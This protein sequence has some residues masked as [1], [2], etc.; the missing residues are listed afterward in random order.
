VV[1][2]EGTP[3]AD[4]SAA[5]QPQSRST[6]LSDFVHGLGAS[7]VVSGGP[8]DDEISGGAGNDTLFGGNGDDT[9]VAALAMMMSM[10]VTAK[11]RSWATKQ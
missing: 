2:S 4:S 1:A 11:T 6:V 10:A 5:P 9:C 7:G 8:A 3:F